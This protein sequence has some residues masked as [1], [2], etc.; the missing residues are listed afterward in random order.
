MTDTL[1]KVRQQP[2]ARFGVKTHI[3]KK[4][5]APIIAAGTLFLAG[6]STCYHPSTVWEYRV[7]RGVTHSSDLQDKLNQAGAEGFA[8]A[9]SQTLAGDANTTPLTIVIL[10]KAKR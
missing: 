4:S 8:I 2:Y 5:I 10:K 9:S 1:L 3:M 6:C 7:V